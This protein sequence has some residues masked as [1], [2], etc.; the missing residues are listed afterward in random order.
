MT[1]QTKKATK[2]ILPLEDFII[3]FYVTTQLPTSMTQQVVQMSLYQS[4][5]ISE[6]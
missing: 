1:K 3:S 4:E 6:W 2:K 5:R